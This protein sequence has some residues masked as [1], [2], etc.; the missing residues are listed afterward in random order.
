METIF[1][2]RK[3]ISTPNRYIRAGE[4]RTQKEWEAEFPGCLSIG[5][6]TWFIDLSDNTRMEDL[7]ANVVDEIFSKNDLHSITYK[8]CAV[9]AIREY[10]KRT[11]QK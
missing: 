5:N 4:R 9:L 11:S 7:A 6:R 3:D 10:V 1:E 8:E 2:L